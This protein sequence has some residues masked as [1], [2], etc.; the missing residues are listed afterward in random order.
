MTTFT[1][2]AANRLATQNGRSI[3]VWDANGNLKADGSTTHA[4][5][6]ANRLISTT[7]DG[8]TTQ[9]NYNGDG[10]RMRLI[11]AGTLTTYTQDYAAPL[12]VVL[13]AKRSTGSTQY[14]YSLSTRPL[15]ECEAATWEYLLADA[16]GSVRQLADANANATLLKSYEPYGSVLNSQ[17]SA[18]SIFG[19]SGDQI[20]STGLIYLRARYMQPQLGIFLSRD[21]W[22]GDMLWPGSMNGWNYVGGN[23]ILYV[24]PSGNLKRDPLSTSKGESATVHLLKARLD[25]TW[26]QYRVLRF[27]KHTY[28]ISA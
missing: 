10:I 12:P 14:V 7:L 22:E 19:Y 1:Y 25:T 20:D 11:E 24:D 21:P 2:D 17:G 6:F 13:Q 5:D 9:F 8:A 3:F 26:Q 23:P 16:L 15:A 18:T 27:R 4:Y 28:S